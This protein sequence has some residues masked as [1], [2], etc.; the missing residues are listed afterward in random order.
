MFM[1]LVRRAVSCSGV[2]MAGA[3]FSES[4]VGAAGV[5][6][7]LDSALGP[8]LPYF[9]SAVVRVFASAPEIR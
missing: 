2:S 6:V 8:V 1:S 4:A 3:C 5:W 9:A 7:V